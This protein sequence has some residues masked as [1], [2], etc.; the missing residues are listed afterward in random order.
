MPVL[1]SK[2]IWVNVAGGNLE[3]KEP[4]FAGSGIGFNR[5]PGMYFLVAGLLVA[6]TSAKMKARLLRNYTAIHTLKEDVLVDT[7]FKFP[8]IRISKLRFAGLG[9][10][11]VS[12]REK[13][14]LVLV[15]AQA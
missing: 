14:T 9:A 10:R 6:Q 3:W 1:K 13:Y 5:A 8:R 4:V 7:L 15:R 11:V 2:K 12:V